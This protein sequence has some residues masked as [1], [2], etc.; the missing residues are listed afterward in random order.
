M[1]LNIFFESEDRDVK[2]YLKALLKRLRI[3][4]ALIAASGFLTGVLFLLEGSPLLA[5]AMFAAGFIALFVAL[6]VVPATFY[7]LKKHERRVTGGEKKTMLR[8]LDDRLELH[9]GALH[10]EILYAHLR[11]ISETKHLYIFEIS[12]GKSGFYLPKNA[13]D[14]EKRELFETLLNGPLRELR[15][16][17]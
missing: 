3:A 15:R 5:G 2:E 9:Q 13:L 17:A 6:I 12:P 1:K 7:S 4:A 8:F 16:K 10:L 14:G 11:R